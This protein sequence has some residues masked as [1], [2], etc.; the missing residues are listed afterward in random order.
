[1]RN[2]CRTVLATVTLTMPALGALT[3]I[4]V[5]AGCQHVE[6]PFVDDL[7]RVEEVTTASVARAQAAPRMEPRP[8]RDF[9][10]VSVEPEIAAVSHW[11][12]GWEDP[13]EDKGS[14]DGRFAWTAEDYFAIGYGPG[15]FIV[16]TIGFPATVVAT[17]PGTLMCSDGKLSRQA[18]GYDHDATPSPMGVPPPIDLLEVGAIDVTS[19]PAAGETPAEGGS[20]MANPGS[21]IQ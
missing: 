20:N 12:L 18:L 8:N 2:G 19:Q 16:N 3:V 4:A 15:R 5:L 7:P 10:A 1:M 6:N 13:F 14:Q 9:A 11:P 17:P 21:P